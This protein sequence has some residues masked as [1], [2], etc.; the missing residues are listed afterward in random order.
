M[1]FDENFHIGEAADGGAG[2]RQV[3]RGGDSLGQGTIAVAGNNFHSM[4]SGWEQGV[5]RG[6]YSFAP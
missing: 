6:G 1:D 2:Q 4:L 3:Q 5:Q